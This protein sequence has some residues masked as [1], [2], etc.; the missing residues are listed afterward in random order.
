MYHPLGVAACLLAWVGSSCIASVVRAHDAPSQLLQRLDQQ[1]EDEPKSARLHLER[2]ALHYEL[3]DPSAGSDDL[4][5]AAALDPALPDVDRLRG[6]VLLAEGQQEAAAASLSRYL[7][8]VPGDTSA[9]AARAQAWAAL[10]RRLEAAAE[11]T[12]VIDQRPSPV[13]DD[14]L[15][16]ARALADASEPRLDDAIRGLD[17][18]QAALGPV[19]ALTWYAV[20]LELARGHHDAALARF[21]ATRANEKQRGPYWMRRGEILERIGRRAEAHE[22]FRR[23]LSAL[24]ALPEH[25]RAIPAWL[26][27]E[28]RATE[29]LRRLSTRV[30]ADMPR[31]VE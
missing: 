30:A 21:E 9:R 29:A 14:Y 7:D 8:A 26:H 10:G 25:R 6:L 11:F 16:R 12:R 27:Q 2:A 20:E 23:A 18:G 13:P 28:T 5:R 24:H 3:R 19:P 4:N 17:E 31:P 15:A 22:A 1:I